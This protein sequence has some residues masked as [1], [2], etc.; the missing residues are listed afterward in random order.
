MDVPVFFCVCVHMFSFF[1]LNGLNVCFWFGLLACSFVLSSHVQ[2]IF[3][4]NVRFDLTA[5]VSAMALCYE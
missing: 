3:G 1:G 4:V 2:C 5:V